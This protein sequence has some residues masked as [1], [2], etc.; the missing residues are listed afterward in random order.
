M[1]PILYV[2]K[3]K[4]QIFWDSL[5]GGVGWGI[6]TVIGAFVLFGVLGVLASRIHAIPVIGEFV[7]N[8]IAEVEK[9][10]GK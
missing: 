5:V 3:S 2:D 10:R 7:Y 1:K 6:G 8:V 9:L 4:G